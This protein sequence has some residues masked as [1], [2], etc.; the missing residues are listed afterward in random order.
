MEN[1][2]IE[3]RIDLEK[4]IDEIQLA[5]AKKLAMLNLQ[6]VINAAKR[7]KNAIKWLEGEDIKN[8]VIKIW[9]AKIFCFDYDIIYWINNK[10][11]SRPIIASGNSL[12]YRKITFAKKKF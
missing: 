12:T 8:I 9:N 3:V 1:I 6:E 4:E 11:I 7:N 2:S 5:K 10:V